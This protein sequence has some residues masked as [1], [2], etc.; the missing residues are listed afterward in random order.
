[1]RTMDIQRL[2]WRVY[3]YISAELFL[4]WDEAEVGAVDGLAARH[5]R[6]AQSA[7]GNADRSE[8]QRPPPTSLEAIRLSLLAQATIQTLERY[9]LAIA[10][11]LQAG[12]GAITQEALEERCHLMAQRMSVLYGLNSPEFFDKSLFRNFIDLLR[13]AQRD[14]NRPRTEACSASRCWRSRPMRSWC[15]RNRFGTA[16]CRSLTHK[17]RRETAFALQEGG[18][19]RPASRAGGAA[20]L[21]FGRETRCGS[22]RLA[23][24]QQSQR[25]VRGTAYRSR[26]RTS[27]SD[28][29]RPRTINANWGNQMN[30]HVAGPRQLDLRRAIRVGLTIAALGLAARAGAFDFQD[31]KLSGSFDTTISYG[32]AWRMGNPNPALI[33]TADGGTA[34]SPNIDDGDLNY[35]QGQPFSQAL[36]ITSELAL[37]YEN[38]GLFARG[39]GLYDYDV[40]DRDTART[41]LSSEAQ[42][43]AGEYVKLLDAFVYGKWQWGSHPFELRVGKQI[44]NWGESTFIQGGL[45]RSTRST[46][47][48][49]ACRRR[50]QGRPTCRR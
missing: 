21:Y 46:C 19:D 24:T 31:G 47:R 8:W 44:V 40:M 23:I 15:C 38:Y 35:K 4:R 49:C 10:L 12:S 9:Y 16:S 13:R 26:Y 25:G 3:P 7:A 36:K 20:G 32:E 50:A 43:I 30:R 17:P 48:S 11:L 27:G 41:P 18:C 33:G 5:L 39:T 6:A 29:S 45:T 28:R 37:K 34:R 2:V 14:S 22:G 1:M 42:R